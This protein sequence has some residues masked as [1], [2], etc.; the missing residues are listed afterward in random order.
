M[1][2]IGGLPP[3]STFDRARGGDRYWSDEVAAT[4]MSAHNIQTTLLAVNGVKKDK[5]PEAP[6]PPAEGYR[7]TGNP[8]VS[9]KLGDHKDEVY[10]ALEDEN[11][12]VPIDTVT[13]FMQS[14]V[15]E[16]GAGN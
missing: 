12:R 16:V 5:W 7:E 4:I 1:A 9:S 14:I 3:G 15:S 2:L 10:A 6:K 8:R 13:D 11:G